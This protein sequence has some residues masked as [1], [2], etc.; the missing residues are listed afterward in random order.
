MPARLVISVAALF[1]L[2]HGLASWLGS[3]RGQYGLAV[4][5]VVVTATALAERAVFGTAARETLRRLGL[6]RPA[7]PGVVAAV[8]ASAALLA[9]I[10]VYSWLTSEPFEMY[11]AWPWL[12]IGLF[13][14][15]G[16]AEETLFRGY[17]YR[18]VRQGRTFRRAAG[19]SMIPFALVHLYLF[20]TL[21][22]PI[23]VASL[24]LAVVISFPLAWL[25]DLGGRTIWAAALLH[26]VIQGAVKLAV[27]TNPSSTFPLLWLAASM[28]VPLV[29]FVVRPR[30]VRR[31]ASD[32]P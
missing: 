8:L 4:A 27:S 19:L 14:Q 13:A 12:A 25:F 11:P 24:T 21:P 26:G 2:F 16:I 23:A 3:D 17:L 31:A 29:V 15:A 22:G 28:T 30:S 18:R 32:R 6:G 9:T 1:A 10:P 5:A 20:A 7:A